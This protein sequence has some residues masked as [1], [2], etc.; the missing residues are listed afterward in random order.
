M[1]VSTL[2]FGAI[3]TIVETSDLQR[4][5][6]N[7][8]FAEHGLDWYWTPETYTDLLKKSG[9]LKRIADFAAT[10]G[11]HVNAKAVHASKVTNF[12]KIIDERG[13]LPRAGVRNLMDRAKS[14]GI[15]IGFATTTGIKQRDAIL[16]ALQPHIARD[17]FDFLGDV[18]QVDHT[19]P[20]PDIYQVAMT[21]LGVTCENCVA[22]E[23]TPTSADS[24]IAAGMTTYGYAGT[25]S[26]GQPFP[27][28]VIMVDVL[29]ASILQ[30][31]A[32]TV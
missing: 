20:A 18:S 13:L 16:D 17:E 22:I 31:R 11:Q 19:K 6:F 30:D 8:A 3:G 12:A 7:L 29:T 4:R 2:L 27:V 1:A 25:S 28:G 21:A 10:Q 14:Q 23:D 32:T 24:A 5:A 9:G 26:S 15:K